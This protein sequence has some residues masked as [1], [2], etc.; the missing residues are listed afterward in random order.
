MHHAPCA[1]PHAAHVIPP[2]GIDNSHL[3]CALVCHDLVYRSR[4]QLREK[5]DRLSELVDGVVEGYHSGFARSI[6]NYSLILQLF[7]E[8]KQQ[9]CGV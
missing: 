6:Q 9:V 7:Q 4:T 2:H 3:C 5:E 8:S 1:T